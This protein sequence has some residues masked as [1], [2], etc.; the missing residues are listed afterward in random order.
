VAGTRGPADSAGRGCCVCG[1]VHRKKKHEMAMK[2]KPLRCTE[3]KK[4]F[5]KLNF[6]VGMR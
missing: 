5:V 4:A 2:D 1:A 6:G 3:K